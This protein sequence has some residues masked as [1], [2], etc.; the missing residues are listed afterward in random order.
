LGDQHLRDFQ[1]NEKTIPTILTTSQKLST[2]VD[3]RNV[4]NIVLMRPVNSMIE[5]KQIIGR[6]TRLFEGKD[7][8]TI[9][10][11]VQAH[12]HFSDPE[13][14][15]EPEELEQPGDGP[16]RIVE[17]AAPDP[18]E[19]DP[20]LERK[21]KT[22]IKLADGKERTI[23]H[24]M[25]TTF[26]SADGRPMSA[27]QFLENMFGALPEFFKDEAELRGIWSKPDTRKAL[28]AGLSDK[29]YGRDTMTEMQRIIEAENSDL[30]DVLAYVAFA[31]HPETREARADQAKVLIHSNYS[32]KQRGFL[33]FVLAQYVK[34]GVDELDQEKLSP[35]LRLKY[36]NAISDAVADL[37]SVEEIRDAFTG[38]QRYLYKSVG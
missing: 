13:W 36:N 8:F 6:G 31:L 7:Y 32:D 22:K 35:L 11:F 27:A 37:G 15:G 9:Y 25:S 24:M 17:R 3:A 26:W 20:D 19:K 28:L 21:Q 14:D 1:D 10:D 33:E 2:G 12:H 5:F 30:F 16:K 29:G 38:F 23:Q 18:K 34:Q 4:R